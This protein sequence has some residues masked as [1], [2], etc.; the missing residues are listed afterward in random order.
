M[1]RPAPP[2]IFS[3]ACRMAVRARAEAL[4]AASDA[5]PFL[6]KAMAEDVLE[7]LS[8][9]RAEAGKV[10]VLGDATG[11]VARE[12]AAQEWQVETAQIGDFDE[13][14][15]W[16]FSDLN[17]IASIQTFDTVNDLPGALIHAR[18]ALAPGGILMASF[19]GAGSLPLLR[20]CMLAGD[21]DRP[22]ARIHPQVDSRAGVDLL[23]R[24]GFARQVSDSVA[25]RASY[26][27]LQSLVGDLRLQGLGNALNDIAPP[28]GKA[29]LTRAEAAFEQACDGDGRAVETFEI[30]TLTGW[31]G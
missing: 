18:K 29:A 9:M 10:L 8:F 21:G 22:A 12:L 19:L 15:P 27:S 24:A 4:R 6:L 20:H 23:Q 17:L 5:E 25:M 30:L 13:E 1:N 3:Q 11:M 31:N 14:Q 7:R 16:P 28:L 2:R 26:A